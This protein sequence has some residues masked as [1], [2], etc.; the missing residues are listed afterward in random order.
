[1]LKK[2]MK[3]IY[4]LLG[5]NEVLAVLQVTTDSICVVSASW[6]CDHIPVLDRALKTLQLVIFLP[7][8]RSDV[9][10]HIPVL[11]FFHSKQI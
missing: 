7:E 11:H 9:L 3:Q 8:W 5:L 1:M 2:T 6:M 10:I 4:T